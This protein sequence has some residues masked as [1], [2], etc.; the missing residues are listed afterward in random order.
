MKI[1]GRYRT[2]LGDKFGG[3][4]LIYPEG[5]E[6]ISDLVIPTTEEQ[7][8]ERD[9]STHSFY[10][11]KKT[12]KLKMNDLIIH[13]RLAKQTNKYFVLYEQKPGQEEKSVLVCWSGWTG[14]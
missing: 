13:A 4:F 7:H 11:V 5:G 10:I 6:E 3:D 8:G 9:D 12:T 14:V 2:T 1:R